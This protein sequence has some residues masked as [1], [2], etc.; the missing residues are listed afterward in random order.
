MQH[1]FNNKTLVLSSSDIEK[2]VTEVGINEIMDSLINRMI[3]AF[4]DY[5]PKYITIPI[6]AGFHYNEPQ[7]G[8]VEWMPL[9]QHGEQVMIKVVGYHP[10]NPKQF[11]LP[12][13]ISTISSYDTSTGQLKGIMDGV[14]LTALRT[15]AASALGSLYLAKPGSSSLGLIGCGAQAVTQLHA[16]SRVFPLNAVYYY[17][18]DPEVV[19]S[20][21][22]RVDM[23]D[24]T[25]N[26]IPS[27]IEKVVESA[28]ILSTAT[29][30]D[31]G[32]GPL[33]NNLKTKEHL[34]INA[35]G[36]DFP[37]KTELPLE[38]L[39][40]SFVC[41]DFLGQALVEGEC[42][43]LKDDE[44][45]ANIFECVQNSDN[46]TDKKHQ[47]TVFDSTG[48]SLEDQVVMDL[49]LEH[50]SAMNLGQMI[51]IETISNDAKNPYEFMKKEQ[52]G[53][54]VIG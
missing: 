41:P 7:Q 29:S 24:L 34:H 16:I 36:A 31:V 40:K 22:D 44:I 47:R 9:Y 28:D 38:L 25:I 6:R 32:E 23:L 13:I 2:I 17:D 3:V 10:N 11:Q 51:E 5:D 48:L 1:T 27:T 20:F 4:E 37:G 33:F 45:G 35:V 42:Q 53:G 54:L 49:F 46:F 15:G 30:I 19:A 18:N 14:F 26:F 12:T 52:V 21:I 8:L 50:A 39:R 43:Q